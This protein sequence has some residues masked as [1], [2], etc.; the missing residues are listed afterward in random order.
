[1]DIDF[2]EQWEV[3]SEEIHQT[4]DQIERKQRGA[5]S[6]CAPV[7]LD[8][9]IGIGIFS[10]SSREKYHTALTECECVDFQ[11]RK[12]PCKHI[13]RLAHELKIL[14]MALDTTKHVN[15][16]QLIDSLN[17]L[18]EDA[19]I[20]V[21]EMLYF[22]IYHPEKLPLKRDPDDK[23]HELLASGLAV[24]LEDINTGVKR[25]AK[26]I[27]LSYLTLDEKK[28][29]KSSSKET[30][31][32]WI[33]NYKPELAKEIAKDTV[34]LSINP[35]IEAHKRSLYRILTNKYRQADTVGLTENQ[36]PQGNW[37]E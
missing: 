20:L 1:M 34:I 15:K 17:A 9:F 5:S 12:L 14:S 23:T 10:G 30:L 37:W 2:S 26:P 18:T 7:A 31:V 3:W 35:E 32:K 27:L 8:E 19:Q 16:W 25:K 29:L 13:Y 33:I 24:E 28:P 36:G 6:K 22:F 11:R 4:E 21:M